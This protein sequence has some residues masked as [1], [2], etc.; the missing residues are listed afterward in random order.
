MPITLITGP[1]NAGKAREVLDAMRGHLA[2][3]EEPLLVVPTR[4]D[5]ER[6]RREL[7]LEGAV[8]G[9]RVERF[10]GL[11]GEVVRRVGASE[12]VLG[13]VA[14]ERVLG[15]LIAGGAGGARRSTPGFV[16]ALVA[17]VA[18]LEVR[19]V[20]P[21]RLEAALKAWASADGVDAAAGVEDLG[22]LYGEYRRLL[23]RI[24]RTDP[25]RRAARALDALRLEPALW[26][27]T[28]VLMYGFDDFGV[29]QLDAIETLGAVLDAPVTVSLTYEPGRTAFGSRA[30]T[31]ETLRPL[32]A[33]HRRLEARAEYYAPPARAALH[34]LERSLF[35]PGLEGREDAAGAVRLLEGGGERAELELVAGEVRALLDGGMRP[36]EI[37]VVHRTPSAVAELLGEVLAA[38][39]IPYALE[40]RVPF[41]NTA[42][43]GALLGALR[44][45]TDAGEAGDLLAWLRA[46]GLLDAPRAGRSA[47]GPGAPRGCHERGAGAGDL[48]GGALAAG[49]ARPPGRGGAAGW[50]GAV[51]ARGA[52]AGVAVQRSPAR[53]RGAAGERRAGRGSG[54]GGRTAGAGGAGRP[55]ARCAPSWASTPPSSRGCSRAW[56]S[57]AA[58][59][60]GRAGWRSSIRWRCGRGGCGRCSCAACRRACSRRARGRRIARCWPRRSAGGWRKPR[61]CGWGGAGRRTRWRRSGT[62]STRRCRGRRSCSC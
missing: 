61:V 16:S 56:R 34:H 3:G 31:F 2:H 25:E 46:P 39:G 22:R 57:S 15:L 18:E 21:A 40:R 11:I 26:G 52:G 33:E 32:A 50:Q 41:A 38:R 30:G 51:R 20:T 48:G 62:R 19:R 23:E 44:S 10:E 59:G 58:S 8:L 36:E 9:A 14:R 29:L 6:Y 24:G 43:G 12:P 54:P 1:A 55:G 28:P 17:T 53:E 5:V 27:G 60:R 47:G 35:E 37:A 7:A 13:R 45:T 49:G 4:A 42:I